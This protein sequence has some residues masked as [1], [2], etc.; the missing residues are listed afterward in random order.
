MILCVLS[1]GCSDSDTTEPEGDFSD[2]YLAYLL[3][4]VDSAE[5]EAVIT[6]YLRLEESAIDRCMGEAGFEYV[7]AP[8]ESIFVPLGFT[9]DPLTDA[10]KFGFGIST[11]D[12]NVEASEVN[13]NDG[14]VSSL[15]QR[16]ATSWND[17]YRSCADRATEMVTEEYG[18]GAA[19]AI[20]SEVNGAVRNDPAVRSA[21]ETWRACMADRGF[22]AA[23]RDDLIAVLTDEYGALDSSGMESFRRREI[24]AAIADA[25][26]GEQLR[27]AEAEATQRHLRELSP[28]SYALLYP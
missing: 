25:E 22:D 18:V 3:G 27:R 15:D 23:S 5:N 4:A 8:P 26:C 28:E 11:I 9:G 19:A 1:A 21:R 14:I 12:S 7:P 17:R 24:A 10:R 6:D 13:P 20:A 2:R 16:L